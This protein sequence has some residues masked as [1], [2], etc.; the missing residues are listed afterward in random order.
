MKRGWSW[1]LLC[2]S[3]WVCWGEFAAGVGFISIWKDWSHIA[4]CSMIASPSFN[5]T[6]LL[7]ERVNY[8]ILTTYFCVWAVLL[9]HLHEIL[10]HNSIFDNHHC[11]AHLSFWSIQGDHF[12]YKRVCAETRPLWTTRVRSTPFLAKSPTDYLPLVFISSSSFSAIWLF[13]FDPHY[14]SLHKCPHTYVK[15]SSLFSLER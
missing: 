2:R 5:L 15:L 7:F 9:A 6:P 11:G 8:N 3:Q 4:L 12:T 10:G 14:C 13:Q 1:A